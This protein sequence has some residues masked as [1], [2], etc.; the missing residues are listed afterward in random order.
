MLRASLADLRGGAVETDGEIPAGDPAFASDEVKIVAPIK[1]R[2]RLSRA[3]EGSYYWRVSFETTL[4]AECRRCLT[5][6]LVPLSESAGVI[7]STDPKA[8]EGEGFYLI[9]PKARDIDLTEPLREE[10][11]LALP[12]FVECRPDCKGLCPTCGADLNEGPCRCA[13][14]ADPRWNALRALTEQD[15]PKD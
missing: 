14:P 5:P 11:L 13:K 1:V 2:G 10:F 4:K 9:A 12:H 8:T 7:L 15:S 6:T 3:G